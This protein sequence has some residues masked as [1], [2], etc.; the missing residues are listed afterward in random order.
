MAVYVISY[1]LNR[2]GQ[3]YNDLFEAIKN[4]GS[5][6]WHCLTSTWL[7]VSNKSAYQIA[8]AIGAHMDANDK[9][10]VNPVVNGSAWAGF[11]GDCE[12]WLQRNL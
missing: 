8:Q 7:V 10:L 9:L 3:N 11:G 4:V 12:S 1:D 2:P 5:D 6:W